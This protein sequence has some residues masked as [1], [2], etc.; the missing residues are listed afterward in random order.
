MKDISIQKT[1]RLSPVSVSTGFTLI[2][3]L[4]V[5]A[6]IALLSS[7]LLPALAKA[8]TRGQA[9]FCLNNVKQLN[10]A[11]M[12]YAHENADRLAYN[13][14]ATEIRQLLAKKQ[15]VNWANSVLNWEL[16]PDNTNYV[17]NTEA[18]LGSYLARNAR[19]FKCP[20]DT[21]LS[22]IQKKAGW[23][24]RTR[25]YSL[26]AMVGDA[27]EFTRAGGNVNNPN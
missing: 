15:P 14:G 12:L 9:V 26:N 17:L 23:R 16:D 13:L 3:L 20:A 5:I 10:L 4:V 2:E 6:V 1:T 7:L 24:E 27:G 22:S 8:K 21:T 18:A 25:S 19:V 11:W